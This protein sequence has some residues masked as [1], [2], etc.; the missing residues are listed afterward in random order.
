MF[1]KNKEIKEL[2]KRVEDLENSVN[3]LIEAN[4]TNSNHIKD[5]LGMFED[6]ESLSIEKA[7]AKKS[8]EPWAGFSVSEITKEGRVALK[9]DWN[10][11]FVDYLKRNGIDAGTEEDTVGVWFASLMKEMGD[12]VDEEQANDIKKTHRMQ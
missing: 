7:L 8:D 9:L 11:E 2:E 12:E 3:T 4:N 10:D 5:F 1:N 6:Y